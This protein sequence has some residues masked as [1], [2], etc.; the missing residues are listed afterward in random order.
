[1]V[2]LRGF[3]LH[4]HDFV[5]SNRHHLLVRIK[6]VDMVASEILFPIRIPL[7]HC[8]TG[9]PFSSLA[10]LPRLIKDK[11]SWINRQVQA[12]ICN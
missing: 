12:E 1:M 11:E 5:T 4:K 6:D 10:S 8:S 2:L 7:V 3:V 9:E